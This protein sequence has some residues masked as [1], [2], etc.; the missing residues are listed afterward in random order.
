MLA[1]TLALA[2]C[3][4]PSAA[5][6]VP[7]DDLALD[8]M[9]LQQLRRAQVS[10]EDTKVPIVGPIF[11]VTSGGVLLGT[12]AYFGFLALLGLFGGPTLGN[13]MV[14]LGLLLGGGGFLTGGLFYLRAA[15]V[16]R[17]DADDRI[18]AIEQ[19][20]LRR[21]GDGVTTTVVTF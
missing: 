16:D 15:R 20:I 3:S 13:A 4:A 21:R 10:I 14:T 5:S 9:T 1:M 18:D 7:S 8:R 17:A 11:M 12:G 19:E 2:L 6:L